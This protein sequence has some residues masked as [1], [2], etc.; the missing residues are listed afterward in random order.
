MRTRSL[1]LAHI[2][3]TAAT[4]TRYFYSL[5]FVPEKN[6]DKKPLK[7]TFRVLVSS[8]KSETA[9]DARPGIS[10]FSWSVFV[11]NFHSIFRFTGLSNRPRQLTV[12]FSLLLRTNQF[13]W[14]L[15]L[16]R[17]KSTPE[18]GSKFE[19]VLATVSLQKF[20][21]SEAGIACV[22]GQQQV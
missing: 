6:K 11:R 17:N 14:R 15:S 16:N 22:C 9:L 12:L 21:V 4:F 10:I 1:T 20:N 7:R 3:R 18:P 19:L 5:A 2:R 8:E 13:N